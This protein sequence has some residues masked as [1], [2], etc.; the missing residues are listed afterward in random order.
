M[1]EATPTEHPP[2]PPL[3]P[4]PVTPT[5]TLPLVGG[6]IELGETV[7][8]AV[9][10]PTW[11]VVDAELPFPSLAVITYKPAGGWGLATLNEPEIW[12]LP[13]GPGT[14]KLH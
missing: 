11:K 9:G 14:M 12:P 2:S 3:N 10:I 8:C 4:N 7:T 5:D 1:G 6:A 13:F